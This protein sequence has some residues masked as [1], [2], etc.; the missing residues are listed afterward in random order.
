MRVVFFV[1][2]FILVNGKYHR[3]SNEAFLK[4]FQR[5]D[6]KKIFKN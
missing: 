5:L 2:S 6:F 3:P 4:S 1:L